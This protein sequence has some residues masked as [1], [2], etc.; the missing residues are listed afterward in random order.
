VPD[1]KSWV[2]VDLNDCNWDR[3][4]SLYLLTDILQRESETGDVMPSPARD[5]ESCLDK[6]PLL[7][8]DKVESPN[9]GAS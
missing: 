6:A 9:I 2:K 7:D 1:R 4:V 5:L 3:V 8:L